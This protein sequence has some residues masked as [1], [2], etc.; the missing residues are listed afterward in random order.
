MCPTARLSSVPNNAPCTKLSPCTLF[1]KLPGV[2]TKSAPEMAPPASKLLRELKR[3]LGQV[4]G[5]VRETARQAAWR[6][7]F[8]RVPYWSGAEETRPEVLRTRYK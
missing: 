3:P 4:A 7:R 5:L 2:E 8:A 6:S 1:E